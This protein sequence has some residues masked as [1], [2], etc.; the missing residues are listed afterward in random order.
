[1][2]EMITADPL[3]L[4]KGSKWTY[5][6]N[7]K[8]YD[9]DTNNVTTKTLQWTTEVVD[10][11]ES[12]GV[13]AYRVRGWPTDLTDYDGTGVGLAIVHRIVARHGGRVWGEA[14]PDRGA[15]FSFTLE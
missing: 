4:S 14:R 8:R 7:V 3:P 6:V 2:Q 1:M 13:V 10:A 11:K 15:T 9:T 5:Q 12:N